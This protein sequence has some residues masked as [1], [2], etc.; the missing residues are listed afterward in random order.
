MARKRNFS[1]QTEGAAAI[2]IALSLFALIA[3]TSLAIDMGQLYTVRN[4]LQNVADAAALAGA[5]QLIQKDANGNATWDTTPTGPAQT[6]A[7]HVAQTQSSLQGQ[8]AVGDTAR[9]D[10]TI[11]FGTWDIK[12]GD[13]STAWTENNV[14]PNAMRVN[15]T[16]AAGSIY[17][18]VS[19]LF[20]QAIGHSTSTVSASATAYLGYTNEVQTGGVQ[21]P[22]ALPASGTNSP[23]ASNGHS[24]WFARLLAPGEAVASG[25]KTIKF[26]DTGGSTVT[27]NSNKLVNGGSNGGAV[28][29]LD[30]NQGYFY[31]PK[32]NP[33]TNSVPDTIKN[34]IAKIYTPSLTGT[35]SVPVYVGDI[36]VGK[37]IYPASEYPWGSAYQK[38][39][40]DNLKAAYN[41][42]NTSGKWRT[43]VV[44]HGPLGT[45]SLLQKSGFMPLARLLKSFWVSEAFACATIQP[46]TTY[47][48]T[49]VNVDITAVTS[50]T[51][52]DGSYTYPKT[53]N[54]TYTGN[55]NVTYTDQKDF[56]DR[57]PNST[58]NVNTV[59]I[60]TTTDTPTVS[61][62]G[63]L[64]GGPT[65]TTVNPSA[66]TTG[67]AFAAVPR[68]VK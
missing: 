40:F 49:F 23:L 4:E 58:W 22:L 17:G 50:G 5:G 19:S 15:I 64:S 52:N 39:I 25:P 36:A 62:P 10:L 1:K 61:P 57:Y 31:T 11:L 51:G 44:V 41:A 24:G 54:D 46:P 33:S 2:I 42:K 7:L 45:S 48:K 59:T 32:A 66:P 68:L 53:I 18:P 47:V 67:G 14:N 28:A 60:Q 55:H 6:A 43:T 63:S 13:P 29:P 8:A 65:P 37:Q 3:V 56:L 35:S 21:L 12:R 16:R 30:P 20:A 27:L 38:P 9:N 34:I 26:R